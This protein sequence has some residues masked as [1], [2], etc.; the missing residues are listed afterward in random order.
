M[1]FP[2]FA[3]GL[4]GVVGN[5]CFVGCSGSMEETDLGPDELRFEIV[6]IKDD[7]RTAEARFLAVGSSI[8]ERLPK[9][10]G[11]IHLLL[12]RGDAAY[13]EAGDVCRGQLGAFQ[14]GVFEVEKV[15]PDG[16]VLRERL[17]QANQILRRDVERR[18]ENIVREVGSLLPEFAVIDQD[19]ELIDASFFKGRTTVINFFFTRCSNPAMCPATTRRLKK[20]L[21][22]ASLSGLT[23]LQ[24]LS[25]SFDSERDVPG[26]LK[27]YAAAYQLDESRFR[28]GTGPKQVMEDLRRQLGISTRKDPELVI[29]H[30]FRAVVVDERLRVVAEILGPNWSV[31]NTLARLRALV[32]EEEK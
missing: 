27:D 8:K 26:L 9:T 6:T 2:S 3:L 11:V 29:D 17:E 22:K 4:M 24:V 20:M 5:T 15:W 14:A 28:L 13:L 7:G 31:E 23:N 25:L 10:E 21:E 12:N 30:T 18:G 32:Q 16:P 1:K 19:G